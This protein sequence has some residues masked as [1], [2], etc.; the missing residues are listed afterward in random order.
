MTVNALILAVIGIHSVITNGVEGVMIGKGT[1]WYTLRDD[2]K[3]VVWDH[4]GYCPGST[5]GLDYLL[6]DHAFARE[7]P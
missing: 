4:P 7:A 1:K 3:S 5:V 2:I 6:S